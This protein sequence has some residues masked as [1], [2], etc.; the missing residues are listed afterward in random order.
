MTYFS[1]LD[2]ILC[3][4]GV[5]LVIFLLVLVKQILSLRRVV[6]T[7]EVHTV[8]R[9]NKTLI[10][11]ADVYDG[12]NISS[13][14]TYYK[15][16]TWLPFLGVSVNI[17]PLSVFDIRLNNYPGYDKNRFQLQISGISYQ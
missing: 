17:L 1:V 14:N 11:G 15:W 10:Y 13:G 16:P 2:W 9:G 7:N 6:P 5:V 8:R 4:V 12:K 3:G